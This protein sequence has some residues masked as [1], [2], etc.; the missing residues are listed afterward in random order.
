M[1]KVVWNV[2][3]IM[4]TRR[5]LGK[6]NE[7][8]KSDQNEQDLSV[9]IEVENIYEDDVTKE[10]MKNEIESMSFWE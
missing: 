8:R 7:A 3:T 10:E 9:A 1:R 4:L 6:M 2:S 5:T